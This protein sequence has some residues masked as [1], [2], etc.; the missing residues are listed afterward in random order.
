MNREETLR[1]GAALNPTEQLLAE[2]NKNATLSMWVGLGSI[3]SLLL[4]CFIGSLWHSDSNQYGSFVVLLAL[5]LISVA[6]FFLVAKRDERW[7]LVCC[8]LNYGGIG[9]AVLLLIRVLGLEP[10]PLQTFLSGLP[11][12]AI[13]FGI[14]SFYVSGAGE[15][16]STLLY[17]GLGALLLLCGLAVF[18]YLDENTEFWLCMAVCA[19]LSC[20]GLGGLIWANGS[21]EFRSVFKGLAVASFS[22]YL[23]ILAVAAVALFVMAAGS[24]SGSG[25]RSK[26]S[27]NSKSGSLDSGGKSG[28]SGLLGGILNRSGS[29]SPVRRTRSFHY[30]F[31]LWY[32]TPYTRYSVIDRMAGDS[33]LE[34]DR[35]RRRYRTQRTV[36]LVVVVLVVAAVI[37]AAILA[38]RG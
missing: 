9:M 31:W 26:R 18:R 3:L 11:A 30:P 24:G 27:K 8:L 13:L 22:I 23:V 20:A 6:L 25:S 19:L 37:A 34:R 35:L 17:C 16:R 4:T 38:G 5:L 32:Y 28:G 15:N 33:E 12:A 1:W 7:Y 21:A 29:A 2:Q 36:M 10:R 14:V